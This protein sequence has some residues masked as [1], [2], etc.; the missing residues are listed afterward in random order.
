MNGVVP[1]VSYMPSWRGEET[2]YSFYFLSSKT[3]FVSEDDLVIF[4][5]ENAPF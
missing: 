2:L 5:T 3:I 4:I 1:P